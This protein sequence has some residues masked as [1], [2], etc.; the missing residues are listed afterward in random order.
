MDLTSIV[1]PVSGDQSMMM[2]YPPGAGDGTLVE[3][4]TAVDFLALTSEHRMLDMAGAPSTVAVE[5][6]VQ[7]LPQLSAP[8]QTNVGAS[9]TQTGPGTADIRTVI[10]GAKTS[11]TSSVQWN[12]FEPYDGATSTTVPTLPAAHAAEDPTVD[13]TTQLRGVAIEL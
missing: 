9:W 7:A 3:I 11:T 8:Q 10:W 6:G 5:Y 1:G 13:P 4:D 12:V 2:R